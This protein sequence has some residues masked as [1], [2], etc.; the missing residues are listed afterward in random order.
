MAT[1]AIIHAAPRFVV[2]DKPAGLLSVPGRPVPGG[3]DN[4]DC[5]AARV[6]VRFPDACGPLIVH[7]LDMETSGL[8][9]LAFDPDA[10]RA[11]SGQFERREVRKAY[12]A[13]VRGRPAADCG[14][15]D[16]PIRPDIDNR[17][18][19]IVDPVRGRAATTLWTVEDLAPGLTRLRLAPLTGRTH[20]LRLHLSHPQGMGLPIIGD[21]LYGGEPAPRLMLH[22]SGLAFRDPDSG[23][24]VQFQIP[25]PF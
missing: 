18:R 13:L 17:P 23:S 5:I 19:Q 15:I 7:R 9:V 24:E 6:R 22:A 12:A 1:L 14:R 16:L 4:Q 25:A 3:P 8:M 10:H 2:V 21:R 20:Q 11:L